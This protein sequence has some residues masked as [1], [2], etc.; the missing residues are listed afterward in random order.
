VFSKKTKI[1][2]SLALGL[3]MTM[4]STGVST[5]IPRVAY[6]DTT[7]SASS[8]GDVTVTTTSGIVTY[9]SA[10]IDDAAMQ[11]TDDYTT[12]RP[13]NKAYSYQFTMFPQNFGNGSTYVKFN[14]TTFNLSD[15]DSVDSLINA[16][17]ATT[18]ITNIT[19][20]DLPTG[21]K[22]NNTDLCTYAD[23]VLKYINGSTTEYY[24]YFKKL[25]VNVTG[26]FERP[27]ETSSSKKETVSQ[28]INYDASKANVFTTSDTGARND[29]NGYIDSVDES[30]WRTLTNV[31]VK[32][33]TSATATCTRSG[34]NSSTATSLVGSTL[35]PWSNLKR[36]DNRTPDFDNTNNNNKMYAAENSVVGVTNLYSGGAATMTPA[37]GNLIALDSSKF[38]DS[39]F[40]VGN[41]TF[42]YNPLAASN[43]SLKYKSTVDLIVKVKAYYSNSN[44][45]IEGVQFRLDDSTNKATFIDK[46]KLNNLIKKCNDLKIAI[47]TDI[48]KYNNYTAFINKLDKANSAYSSTTNTQIEVDS[49]VNALQSAY[50]ACTKK[51]DNQL[52]L[53]AVCDGLIYTTYDTDAA[54]IESKLVGT[55]FAGSTVSNVNN[56]G[57]G[58]ITFTVEANG[59]IIEI[60]ETYE[61][62]KVGNITI[63]GTD[64]IDTRGGSI[65]L[66]ANIEPK[67]AAVKTV[68]WSIVG[69][70]DNNIAE[71]DSDGTVAATKVADG[72]IVVKA[73]ANDGSNIYGE[74][75][76][77]INNQTI[78]VSSDIENAFEHYDFTVF[79]DESEVK[80]TLSEAFSNSNVS[81]SNFKND[82]TNGKVTFIATV[83]TVTADISGEYE[84][85]GDV[86]EAKQSLLDTIDAASTTM[87]A[88]TVSENG[89][90]IDPED[91]WATQ[92]NFNALESVNNKAKKVYLN[93]NSSDADCNDIQAKLEEAII[94]FNDSKKY[95]TRD[96][97]EIKQLKITGSALVLKTLNVEAYDPNNN[98]INSGLSYQWYRLKNNNIADERVEIGSDSKSY[99]LEGTDRD[100]YIMVEVT[101]KD[102]EGIDSDIVGP[103]A[104][105]ISSNSSGGS[106]SSSSSSRSSS[107]TESSDSLRGNSNSLPAGN[108]SNSISGSNNNILD[109][110]NNQNNFQWKKNADG[111][112]ILSNKDGQALV[113]WQ[114]IDNK[115]YLTNPGGIILIGW[116][117]N[118]ENW[119][120]LNQSGEMMTGWLKDIDGN[121]YYLNRSGE[122]KTG[123]LKDTDGNWY[124]LKGNGAMAVNEYIDG[125]YLGASG[126]WEI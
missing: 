63:T 89:S 17:L 85:A 87:A 39:T 44:N 45:L 18:G 54:H 77:I 26:T 59:E 117:R 124:Y 29:C 115:W 76:I 52:A 107:T 67:D 13:A 122:M 126:A 111:T 32:L 37:A 101:Y 109:I 75:E 7:T 74:K 56:D 110:T 2:I 65:T 19:S 30:Q 82:R 20:S 84:I 97:T 98:K 15:Y 99:T 116:Q 6:A 34:V 28:S 62:I 23:K 121:W 103:I 9:H 22:T 57:K 88:V 81:I 40:T 91:E 100:A 10:D 68:T 125:Y 49:E 119:Y 24:A 42:V 105:R 41:T 5:S 80:D 95:G 86:S 72:T 35:S 16:A 104:K 33:E 120:Y 43:D 123:W 27:Q 106:G 94:E 69:G 31:L 50:E 25:N 12:Y 51:S 78:I 64:S 113:G 47:G 1:K 108:G 48:S 93:S 14:G 102:N 58:N 70:N 83:G 112:M 96:Y 3:S 79:T 36:S 46:T 4:I 21:N 90:D 11:L 61:I 55:P 114:E 71:I 92:E 53:E 66:G 8:G 73:T 118:N 60:S 38:N